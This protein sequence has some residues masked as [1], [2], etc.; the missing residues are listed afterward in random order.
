MNI[1]GITAVGSIADLVTC[2]AAII[3]VSVARKTFRADHERRKKQA[4]IE[5]YRSIGDKCDE[6]LIQIE[7][8]FPKDAVVTYDVIKTNK[9][10]YYKIVHYLNLMEEMSV[11]INKDVFDIKIFSRIAGRHSIRWF[12]KLKNVIEGIRNESDSNYRYS[13]FTT[14]VET[15]ERDFFP[16]ST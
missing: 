13:D 1:N 14:M 16:K 10:T 5:F 8:D 6:L 11:G 4:T 9:D 15:L 3:G 12:E 7:N 2:V